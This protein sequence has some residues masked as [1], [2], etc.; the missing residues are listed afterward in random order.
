MKSCRALQAN[1]PVG[2]VDHDTSEPATF[3]AF[4]SCLCYLFMALEAMLRLLLLGF[5]IC[6]D[7]CVEFLMI[8]EYC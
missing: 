1:G 7:D 6:C 5:A 4:Y 3:A 8:V 2:L